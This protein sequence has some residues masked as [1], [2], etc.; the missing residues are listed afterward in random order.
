M[1]DFICCFVFLSPFCYSIVFLKTHTIWKNKS[2]KRK[3]NTDEIYVTALDT[4]EGKVEMEQ[5]STSKTEN[6]KLVWQFSWIQLSLFLLLSLPPHVHGTGTQQ[7]CLLLNCMK[8][9]GLLKQEVEHGWHV[10]IGRLLF[11]WQNIFRGYCNGCVNI[12]IIIPLSYFTFKS[13]PQ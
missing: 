3:K 7:L 11:Y 13:L 4:K 9:A 5:S 6:Q 1:W 2:R 8:K 12:H 10:V